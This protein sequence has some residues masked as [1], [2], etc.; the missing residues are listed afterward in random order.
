MEE[1]IWAIPID[2]QARVTGVMRLEPGSLMVDP[3]AQWFLELPLDRTPPE[4][5]SRLHALRFRP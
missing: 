2:T 5:G 1:A 4:I 3:A